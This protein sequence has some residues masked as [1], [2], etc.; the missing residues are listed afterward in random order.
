M[1]HILF[2]KNAMKNLKLLQHTGAG[3]GGRASEEDLQQEEVKV[4]LARSG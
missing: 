1:S 4:G 3:D 2:F